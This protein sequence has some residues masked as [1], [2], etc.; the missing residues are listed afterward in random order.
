MK[1]MPRKRPGLPT[2]PASLPIEIVEVLLAITASLGAAALN[3]FSTACLTPMIS[4]TAS[5][6][7]CPSATASSAVGAAQTLRSTVAAAP[8]GMS[9]ADSKA[10]ASSRTRSRLRRAMSAETSARATR[11]PASARIWAMPPPIYPAPT[12][13]ALCVKLVTL[14][15]RIDGGHL[16]R[17]GRCWV[18]S[19]AQP[20]RHQQLRQFQPDD[21]LAER[22]HLGVVGQHGPRHRVAVVG[23]RGPDP[24]HL[25]GR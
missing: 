13:A 2:A 25:V 22:E 16:R 7:N 20:L 17:R 1:W 6:M 10:R 5:M 23:G 24:L 21:P 8:A 4:G 11:M 15:V 14:L 9:P 12:T 18:E 19:V 3:R